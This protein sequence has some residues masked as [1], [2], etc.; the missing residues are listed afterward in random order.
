MLLKFNGNI[1]LVNGKPLGYEKPAGEGIIFLDSYSAGY[2]KTASLA[3]NYDIFFEIFEPNEELTLTEFTVCDGHSTQYGYS[4]TQSDKPKIIDKIF[5]NNLSDAKDDLTTWAAAASDFTLENMDTGDKEG[6]YYIH[7]YVLDTPLVMTPGKR[8][9]I[10]VIG[11]NSSSTENV[12]KYSSES[13][14]RTKTTICV[15]YTDDYF[16]ADNIA[17]YTVDK[18]LTGTGFALKLNGT[19]V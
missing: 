16:T 15:A 1:I 7:H 6:S 11:N 8:Y 18:V 17:A 13:P 4:S 12:I 3:S 2:V 19:N 10:P 9:F 14:T 5:C